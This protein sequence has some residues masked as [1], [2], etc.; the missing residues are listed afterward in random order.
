MKI[1]AEKNRN[2]Q[3]CVANCKIKRSKFLSRRG[4]FDLKALGGGLRD[5]PEQSEAYSRPEYRELVV[6]WV[7]GHPVALGQILRRL[8]GAEQAFEHLAIVWII[9]KRRRLVFHL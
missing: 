2:M 8:V 7:E 9:L 4:N 1:W 5:P 3:G 6:S